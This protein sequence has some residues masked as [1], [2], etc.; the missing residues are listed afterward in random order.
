MLLRKAAGSGPAKRAFCHDNDDDSHD[1]D[2]VPKKMPKKTSASSRAC[3]P[4]RP[5]MWF[6]DPYGVDPIAIPFGSDDTMYDVKAELK[7]SGMIQALASVSMSAFQ[8]VQYNCGKKV[9]LDVS[10]RSAAED[11]DNTYAT[12]F[13]VVVFDN[14]PPSKENTTP[15]VAIKV[16]GNVA[17]SAPH[18]SRS[19]GR[20][21]S[22]LPASSTAKTMMSAAMM[23]LLDAL[24]APSGKCASAPM[25]LTLDD[26]EEE[27]K[28]KGSG[29]LKELRLE[30]NV[31]PSD[32]AQPPER[33]SGHRPL[34]IQ[35]AATRKSSAPI[36]RG[37][38]RWSGAT[39]SAVS[40]IKAEVP[41]QQRQDPPL[42]TSSQCPHCGQFL[43]SFS[44]KGAKR[45]VVCQFH[46]LCGYEVNMYI[47]N[48]YVSFILHTSLIV[49]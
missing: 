8:V 47:M 38:S 33:S 36:M 1:E 34:S 3:K 25:D 30:D 24:P 7:S 49:I 20:S 45:C 23:P 46:E 39:S 10:A 9:P 14:I 15:L 19:G 40:G 27:G 42:Q 17:S 22:N 37:A 31:E 41:Q 18:I 26:S 35:S 11:F 16:E 13:Q 6:H 12:P 32:A 5:M 43:P 29:K 2:K 44:K 4:Q 48:E 21:S 28:R